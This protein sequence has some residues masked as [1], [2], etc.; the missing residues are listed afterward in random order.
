MIPDELF[1][2]FYNDPKYDGT[3]IFYAW[4]KEHLEQ[5]SRILN[6]GAGP[7]TGSPKRN[8][9]GTVAHITGADIDPVVLKNSEL[10]S[11]VLIENGKLPLES[12]QF[13][14]VFSDFVLEH[15]EHPDLYLAEVYRVLKP[16]GSFLFRTPNRFHYVALISA[17]T[18]HSFHE[19]VA[20]PV[21]GLA[22][23]AHKPWPTFYRMNSRS[24]LRRQAKTA[25]FR[26]CE[27]RMIEAEPS[28][29]MFHTVPFLA[30]VGYERM[31]NA[32]RLL[33]GARCTILGKS[34]K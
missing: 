5:S 29:L 15:V 26:E 13:D 33:A 31:V 11:A 17:L 2:R 12:S 20:N 3:L 23:D 7:E 21:R 32:T 22:D 16:G 9:R 28:Y 1:N 4:I 18:P 27:F 24:T 30:G 34:I 8:L 14:V 25:G 6:L 19:R 10:D